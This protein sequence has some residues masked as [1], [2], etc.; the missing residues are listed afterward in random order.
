LIGPPAASCSD[1][2]SASNLDVFTDEMAN[3]TMNSAISSVIMSA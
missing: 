1:F 2:E 3:I